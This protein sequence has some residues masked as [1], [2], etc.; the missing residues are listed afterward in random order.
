MGLFDFLFKKKESNDKITKALNKE[1]YGYETPIL[2]NPPAREIA[3]KNREKQ[4]EQSYE[5][6]IRHINDAIE[7]GRLNTTYHISTFNN[8]HISDLNIVIAGRR[9][10]KAGFKV[11]FK[12]HIHT[13][14]VT[15]DPLKNKYVELEKPTK[16]ITRYVEISWK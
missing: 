14:N 10:R 3:L 16:T 15:Y 2:T 13:D 7:R 12:R 4:I 6:L 1:I 9:L 8:G 11:K 5:N